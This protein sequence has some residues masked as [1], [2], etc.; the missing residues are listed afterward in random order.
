MIKI[1]VVL[2]MRIRTNKT[3]RAVPM[4]WR[5]LRHLIRTMHAISLVPSIHLQTSQRAT[6]RSPPFTSIQTVGTLE[7][8][9]PTAR[10]LASTMSVT[11]PRRRE[12]RHEEC[13]VAEKRVGRRHLAQ[14][15]M[16]A[17]NRGRRGEFLTMMNQRM[18]MSNQRELI[19]QA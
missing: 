3:I 1:P 4:Q 8:A 5:Q 14:T 10:Q 9:A 19:L 6:K 17:R 15:M 18:T 12:R 2:M 13:A 7:C 11:R 16:P